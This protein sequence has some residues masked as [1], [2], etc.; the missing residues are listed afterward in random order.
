[1]TVCM[2]THLTHAPRE[3]HNV[4]P[5]LQEL[6]E[7]AAPH[8]HGPVRAHERAEVAVAPRVCRIDALQAHQDVVSDKK[9]CRRALGFEAWR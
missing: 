9:A 4:L 8:G 5:V 2:C 3:E 6:E 7:V 1:M